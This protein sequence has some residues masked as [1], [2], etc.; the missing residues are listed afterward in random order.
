MLIASLIEFLIATPKGKN[1][2]IHFANFDRASS[3]VIWLR[4]ARFWVA[5]RS[6]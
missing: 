6:K 1:H 4:W 3:R 2:N 5:G